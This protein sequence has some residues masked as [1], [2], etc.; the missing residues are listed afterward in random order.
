M[1]KIGFMAFGVLAVSA[2][3]ASAQSSVTLFGV[4]D[5]GVTRIAASGAG[6]RTG[7][8]NGSSAPSRLGFRGTEDLGGG[9][10][11]GFWLE[12]ALG[13]DSGTGTAGGSFLF[14]RRSTVSLSNQW[15]ELRLGRDFA[16]TW[17]NVSLLDP[18]NARGVGTSQAA[19][20]F[21][22]TTNWNNNSFG[23]ILPASLGG[24]YGQFQYA[25]GEKSS[26]AANDK[27]G[28]S[29]GTRLG[30]QK[31]A[32]NVAVAYTEFRQVIGASDVAPL[33]IGRDLKVGN[34]AATWDFGVI[35]PVVFYG[36]ERVV[37]NPV[38]NNR[39]DSLLLGATAPMGQGE[40]RATVARHDMKDSNADFNKIA[41]G[42]GY[43]MSRR[44][45]LYVNLA[46]L[47]NKG[48]STRSLSADGVATLAPIRAGGRSN[49]IDVG[50]RHSF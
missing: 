2:G 45:Q 27:Q 26:T 18:F 23:Y 34:I 49:G 41:L 39:L 21:G 46:R 32:L 10:A 37:G 14:Q 40:L 30:W 11:A 31:D 42:Y 16:P 28:N 15:G 5:V 19:N 43:F 35:K 3:T 36:Q 1:K 33:A 13:V 48:S 7:L 4:V 20:N 44:T 12:G 17:W 6:D 24:F 38:G 50:I 9:L 29:F 25:F 8:S 47:S 22:Y